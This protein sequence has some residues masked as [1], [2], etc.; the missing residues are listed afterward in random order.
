MQEKVIYLAGGCFWGLQAYFQRIRGVL[1]T[2]CGY[3]NGH[4]THPRYEDVCH[5]HTGHAETVKV[6]YDADVIGLTE[7]LRYFLRV[8]DPV[9]VNRQGND[10]GTQYRSG[11]YYT[12]IADEM[13]IRAILTAEQKHHKLPIAVENQPLQQFYPAETEHQDYLIKHPEGY[14]HI[15]LRQADVP[16]PVEHEVSEASS[17][18]DVQQFHKPADAQLRQQLSEEQYRITQQA[19]TEYP[20]SHDYDHL[21]A[22]GSMS[23][24]SAASR[25][26]VRE[27]SLTLVVVGPA[28]VSLWLSMSSAHIVTAVMVCSEPRCAAAMLIRIWG[29][30]FQMDRVSVVACVIALMA[31]ACA[32]SLM[33]KWMKRGM[34]L[35]KNG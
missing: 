15:G 18:F 33:Q 5:H 1:T 28:S 3:A 19:G 4:T 2:E 8:V 6:V 22:P 17:G 23:M 27:T 11:V 32:L 13:L 14:C 29:M 20:F 25:Y 21:F 12:D 7:I 10:V 34:V 9:S 35:I 24:W 30:Y 16:L 26:L 31:Q